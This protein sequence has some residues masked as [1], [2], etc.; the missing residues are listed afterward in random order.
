MV[1]TAFKLPEEQGVNLNYM[2]SKVFTVI[3]K[4]IPPSSTSKKLPCQ[5]LPGNQIPNDIYTLC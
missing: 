5:L 3:T 2:N 4:N 1:R